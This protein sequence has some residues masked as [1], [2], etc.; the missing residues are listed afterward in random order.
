MINFQ[1]TTMKNVHPLV[2][3]HSQIFNPYKNNACMVKASPESFI[4]QM[5]ESADTNLKG[6][7]GLTLHSVSRP[8]KLGSLS[9]ETV[10]VFLQSAWNKTFSISYYPIIKRL[11]EDGTFP[12][13]VVYPAKIP[14]AVEHIP[15]P[16]VQGQTTASKFKSFSQSSESIV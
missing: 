16:S 1:C 11:Q 6:K 14:R 7:L 2:A 8:A 5:G 3:T 13:G 12:E 9:R 10:V 15:R 4:I